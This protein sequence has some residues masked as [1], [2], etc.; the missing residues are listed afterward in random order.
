MKRFR[1]KLGILGGVALAL[2]C[3]LGS[4]AESEPQ[5]AWPQDAPIESEWVPVDTTLALAPA[6]P[7]PAAPVAAAN[8]EA[9]FAAPGT[10]M[11]ADAQA[12]K[13]ETKKPAA[14]PDSKLKVTGNYRLR[15]ESRQN[16]DFIYNRPG[17]DGK[18]DN[19]DN[20]LLHRLRINVDYKVNPYIQAHVTFQDSR[21]WGSD[22]IDH[23]LLDTRYANIF[24]NRT[25]LH[26]AWL[27]LK[28]CEAPVWLQVGRQQL[29]F[30]D[31]R[32]VGGFNWS[33]NAR[34][35][36]AARLIYEQGNF[37]LDVFA[38]NVVR[39]D[40]NA[41]DNADFDDDFYGIYASMKNLPQGTQDIYLF[42][43]DNEVKNLEEYTLGTRIDGKKGCL[44]WNLEGAYQWGTSV[45]TVQPYPVV[46]QLPGKGF[47][48]HSYGPEYLDHKAW[49]VHAELGYTCPQ[50][51]YKPRLAI[52]YNYATGDEDPYDNENNTFDNL[53]PTNHLFY[54]YMD[55]FSWRNMHN[56]A[57]KLSW[58]CSE[59]LSF[60]THW[61]MF[62]LDEEQYDA[63]Y[64]APGAVLRNAKG[65]DVSDFV[66]HE[67]DIVATYKATKDWSIELGYGH[68]FAEDYVA[69]T[70]PK[71]NA[72]ADDADFVYVMSTWNF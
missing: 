46:F 72:G 25:D 32:L 6:M 52:E 22:E 11:V 15:Y 17:V 20:F 33:N 42:Y 48:P 59:K 3:G 27:K 4:W 21:E 26:E 63:W 31:E 9:P 8:V 30:G 5:A 14:K 23:D 57:L 67:L 65:N 49:A 66:G 58:T 68:F 69:D 39:V 18:P 61:H 13:P 1:G 71:S 24:E 56:P 40:S 54:G 47:A 60:K 45:D 62:W 55:F 37:K 10:L 2:V 53:F 38:A 7:L 36:D 41:W 44:D 28:L 70:A 35:F 12:T 19:D 29:L 64:N 51:C 34:S 43:R 16:Y 50:L